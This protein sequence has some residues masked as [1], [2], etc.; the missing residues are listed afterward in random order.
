MNRIIIFPISEARGIFRGKLVYDSEKK[1]PYVYLDSVSKLR[2][3]DKDEEIEEQQEHPP[4]TEKIIDEMRKN[5]RVN[6]P[7]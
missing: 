7:N 6:K 5:E 3:V 1:R 4:S 2:F